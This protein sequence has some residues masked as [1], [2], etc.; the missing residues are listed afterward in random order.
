[1]PNS[2]V[3]SLSPCLILKYYRAAHRHRSR[4]CVEKTK[5][6]VIGEEL[7]TFDYEKYINAADKGLIP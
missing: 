5:I 2:L 1:M 4:W 3:L 6:D 7:A